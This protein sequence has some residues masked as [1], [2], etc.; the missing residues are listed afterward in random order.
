MS[1]FIDGILIILRNSDK[2]YALTFMTLFCIYGMHCLLNSIKPQNCFSI[3]SGISHYTKYIDGTADT[4]FQIRNMILVCLSSHI[5]SRIYFYD[6]H[7]GF[8]LLL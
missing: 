4:T 2:L 3:S 7:Y 8:S 6:L 1:Q 5:R